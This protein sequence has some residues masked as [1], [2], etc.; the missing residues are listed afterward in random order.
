MAIKDDVKAIREQI[1][2]EEQFLESVIKG[3]RIFKKYKYPIIGLVAFVVL[4][5]SGYSFMDYLKEKNLN[6][7]N[8]AYERLR[9]NPNNK[10]ALAILKDKNPK[11]YEVFLFS[12]ASKAQSAKEL[13]EVVNSSV[14]PILKS[15]AVYE[16]GDGDA[17]ILKDVQILLRG[18]ALLKDNKI[19][20]AKETFSQIALTSPL[21]NIV[22]KLSHYRGGK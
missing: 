9:T 18:Y 7:S 15:L 6:E 5:A 22:K 21:Q 19:E 20:K 2:A 13:K 12:K 8:I 11:L 10:E 14:D 17:K 4:F 3:E 16:L 1:G